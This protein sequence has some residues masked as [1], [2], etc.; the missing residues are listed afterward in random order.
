MLCVDFLST[1]SLHVS[2]TEF[3]LVIAA[4]E[5]NCVKKGFPAD[6][7]SKN[8]HSLFQNETAVNSMLSL[9]GTSLVV[10]FTRKVWSLPHKYLV[11][12]KMKEI[13]IIRKF[14]TLL[15][16]LKEDLDIHFVIDLSF[17]GID[18]SN[19]L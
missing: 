17:F 5:Q 16:K 9:T 10:E 12:N 4:N 14:K 11:T 19:V 13:R 7:N 1:S 8:I 2:P 3:A 6:R 18:H 15:N